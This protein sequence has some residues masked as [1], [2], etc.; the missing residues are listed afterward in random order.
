MNRNEE[1]QAL[2]QEL[3]PTPPA[4]AG[5]TERALRRRRRDRRLRVFPQQQE[6]SAHAHRQDAQGQDRVET[7]PA[8]QG[9]DFICHVSYLPRS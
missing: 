5:T 7:R 9:S 1:Y 8:Q 2:L 4:L 3:E 6:I